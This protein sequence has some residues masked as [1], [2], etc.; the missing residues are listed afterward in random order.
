MTTTMTK[1][2]CTKAEHRY[3]FIHNC[4]YKLHLL[5]RSMME[6]DDYWI[7]EDEFAD[8]RKE[9]GLKH[10]IN[11]TTSVQFAVLHVLKFNNYEVDKKTLRAY[12]DRYCEM[13]IPNNN[14]QPLA[15]EMASVTLKG[16]AEVMGWNEDEIED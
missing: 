13:D 12:Y 1:S 8:I 6:D 10:N 4:L 9:Y 3:R 7:L 15:T 11:E 14:F 16:Y 5:D 2:K